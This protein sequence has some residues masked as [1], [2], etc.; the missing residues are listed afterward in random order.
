MREVDVALTMG[1]SFTRTRLVR[2]DARTSWW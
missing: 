1:V 2:Q